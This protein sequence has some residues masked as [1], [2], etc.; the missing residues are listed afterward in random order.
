MFKIFLVIVSII[1]LTTTYGCSFIQKKFA[2]KQKPMQNQEEQQY[3]DNQDKPIPV[4]PQ[5]S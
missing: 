4:N 2:K 5:H 3:Q 1:L